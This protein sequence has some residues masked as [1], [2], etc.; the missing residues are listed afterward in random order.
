MGLC[1]SAEPP[2]SA[3]NKK[4]NQRIE[5]ALRKAHQKEENED[6]KKMLL[7][8]AGQSGKSTLFKQTQLLYGKKLKKEEM[9]SYIPI[10]VGNT[11]S[12]MQTLVEKSEEFASEKKDGKDK[13]MH[14][15]TE[16]AK[17]VLASDRETLNSELGAAIKTLW[18]D[19]GIQNTFNE[20]HEFQLIDSASYYFSRIDDISSEGWFPNEEDV[21]RSR[22][23]TTGIVT[24]Q[25]VVQEHHF[26]MFDVGGQKSERKKV[27]TFL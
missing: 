25:F 13:Y 6:A 3:E 15:C 7:L 20:K 27:G 26:K 24:T 2:G 10:I 11:I 23:R 21:L 4:R 22:A 5:E 8:G 18:A 14:S 9:E 1:A 16:E 19:P 17:I 12:S